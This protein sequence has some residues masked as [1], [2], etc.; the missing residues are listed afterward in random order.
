MLKGFLAPMKYM[1]GSASGCVVFGG[2]GY[3]LILASG[4]VFV[5]KRKGDFCCNVF[6]GVLLLLL[7]WF[8][9]LMKIDFPNVAKILW[10]NKCTC[11]PSLKSNMSA[12]VFTDSSSAPLVSS[13]RDS[14]SSATMSGSGGSLGCVNSLHIKGEAIDQIFCGM[15]LRGSDLLISEWKSFVG[16]PLLLLA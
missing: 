6:R 5:Q 16:L 11:S 13:S 15:T 3:L 4:L 8:C 1:D 2:L 7:T 10:E 12:R 14:L 9:K